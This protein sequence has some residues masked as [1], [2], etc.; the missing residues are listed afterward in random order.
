MIFPSICRIVFYLDKLRGQVLRGTLR[1]AET[2]RVQDQVQLVNILLVIEE[3]LV[4]K[5][6]VNYA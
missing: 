3:E 2:T 1:T 4:I 6:T 5:R